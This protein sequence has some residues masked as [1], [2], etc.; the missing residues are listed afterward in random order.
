[1]LK[2]K[3]S[4]AKIL[5]KAKDRG[6]ENNTKNINNKPIYKKLQLSIKKAYKR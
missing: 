3:L 5:Q 2:Q 6:C 1:M 4:P